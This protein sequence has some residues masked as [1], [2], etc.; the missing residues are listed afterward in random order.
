MITSPKTV[1]TDL[2]A[3]I[4]RLRRAPANMIS[5]SGSGVDGEIGSEP[6]FAVAV[7]VFVIEPAL[8]SVDLTV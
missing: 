1:I 7:A 3:V 5:T 4:P 2:S 8:T 6:N